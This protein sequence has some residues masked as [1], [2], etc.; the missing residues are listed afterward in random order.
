M[1]CNSHRYH[2]FGAAINN[3]LAP[4]S[5]VDCCFALVK[6]YFEREADTELKYRALHGLGGMFIRKSELLVHNKKLVGAC[7]RESAALKL[8]MRMLDVILEF[9]E[10][11]EAVLI[12]AS[13]SAK[14]SDKPHSKHSG[15]VTQMDSGAS[16]QVFTAHLRRL[17]DLLYD[18]DA[19]V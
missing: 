10:H 7:L 18:S 16:A 17:L 5:T 2:D 12:A 8:K 13:E 9:L 19:M 3:D 4:E 1:H 15:D 14:K 11:E 6:S